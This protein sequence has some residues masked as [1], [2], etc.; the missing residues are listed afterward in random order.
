MNSGRNETLRPSRKAIVFPLFRFAP[1]ELNMR[2]NSR[3]CSSSKKICS[4]FMGSNH[5]ERDEN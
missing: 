1:H 5:T 2:E 3:A 4:V